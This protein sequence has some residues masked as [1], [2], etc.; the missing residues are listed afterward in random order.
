MKK[1]V[2]HST[3]LSKKYSLSSK[4]LNQYFITSE[5][6]FDIN[7]GDY[8]YVQAFEREFHRLY[9]KKQI[10]E[11]S[12]KTFKTKHLK[13]YVLNHLTVNAHSK[14]DFM[15]EYYH[16]QENKDRKE[17]IDKMIEF[18]LSKRDG[19][20]KQ[21]L[22]I[23]YRAPETGIVFFPEDIRQMRE[24]G[25]KVAIVCHELGMNVVRPY[26]KDITVRVC[27]EANATFF[28][29]QMDEEEARKFGFH[30]RS[31]YTRVWNTISL[32]PLKPTLDRSP[33]ILFFGLIRPNKGLL[34]ALQLVEILHKHQSPMKVMI[35]GKCEIENPL[36][37]RWLMKIDSPVI[38]S[39][40]KV[41]ESYQKNLEIYV[42][43]TEKEMV[44]VIDQC[45]YAYKPDGKGYAN[46]SSS[47]INL[48]TFKTILF[49]KSSSFTPSILTN[50]KSRFF[51]S[52]IFQK[53]IS[54]HLLDNKTPSAMYVYHI[55]EK[56]EKNPLLKKKILQKAN[57]YIKTYIQP[58]NIIN[59]FL[60]DLQ[61][62]I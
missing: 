25:I 61:K 54:T 19:K 23:Q 41:K 36:V 24:K 38:S 2:L 40:L 62:T 30:G 46:N 11:I 50:P 31:F 56:L 32:P 58:K 14:K 10:E 20:K 37:K 52:M 8:D 44:Q 57:A 53:K 29:N 59:S 34:S 42:N 21:F 15:R 17:F 7:T 1:K 18:I 51:G 28:F 26:F 49:T 47:L 48:M 13:E 9:P 3:K 27:N 35:M 22:I 39:D 55:I 12:S 4:S 60:Q 33:N 6:F 45:Q 43:P 5:P 16:F